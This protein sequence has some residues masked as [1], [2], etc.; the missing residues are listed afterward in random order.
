[1]DRRKI[2]EEIFKILFQIDF[3]QEEELKEQIEISLQDQLKPGEEQEFKKEKEEAYMRQKIADLCGR[4]KEI[5]AM[6]DEKATGWKTNRMA[7]VD[8]TLIRLAV[9]EM[10]FEDDIPTKVAI[11]EA[12]ELAKKYGSNTSPSFI[13]GVL[14]KL[15]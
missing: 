7:K 5:D 14:A 6:I 15:A 13:N 4:C 2:R 10:K 8:L 9:Y 3:Y 12:V 1:M 11:N